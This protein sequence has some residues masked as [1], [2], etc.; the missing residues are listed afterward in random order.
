M[1][2]KVASLRHMDREVTF[3]MKKWICM[4]VALML[5]SGAAMA[6]VPGNRLGFELLRELSDGTKNQVLSPVSLAAALSMAAQGAEG[7]TKQQMLAALGEENPFEAE[8]VLESLVE[9]GLR[10]ANAAFLPGEIVP[11]AQYISD[12]EQ[13][14]CAKWFDREETSVDSINRWVEDMTDGMID[15]A[16]ERIP[17]EVVLT[18]VN[19]IALDAKWAVTFDPDLN[20]EDV[21][22]APQGDVEAVFM[23]N[24]F[25]AGYGERDN[26][27][28][29]K[30]NYRNA[31][32]LAFYAA[33][34]QA[35]GMDAVLEGLCAEGLDY[36]HFG[37]EMSMVRL[38]MPKT[39]IAAANDFT[40]V[41]PAMGMER[42]FSDAAEFSGITEEIPVALGAVFQKARL[43]LDEEGTRAAAATM[44]MAK[45][46]GAYNP[47]M[48]VE[49]NMNRPFAFVIAHEGTGAVCFAGIVVDPNGN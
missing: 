24:E 21:F 44:V 27:Q 9:T 1:E 25:F 39:D 35:G 19:A 31:D 26:V 43:I 7:E 22:H 2:Q 13:L 40:D 16:V 11:K 23:H 8:M 46:T 15:S 48:I 36:F 17:E 14:F 28:L 10:H 3:F 29:L 38:S 5:L 4:L 41:L 18:L 34:P 42:A 32:G 47:E 6:E 30:L 37:E 33:L 45:V 49:F 20:S 12:L